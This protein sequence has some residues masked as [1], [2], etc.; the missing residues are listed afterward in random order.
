MRILTVED[1]FV[2]LMDIGDMLEELGHECIAAT[3]A[4]AV[5]ESF[6]NDDGIDLA[7]TDVTL[8]WHDWRPTDQGFP[9]ALAQYADH[10]MLWF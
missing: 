3:S 6:G 9:P 7:M 4:E 2:V 8:P 5:L 1:D 10:R